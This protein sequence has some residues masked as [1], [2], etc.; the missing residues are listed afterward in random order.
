MRLCRVRW[1]HKQ[2]EQGVAKPEQGPSLQIYNQQSLQKTHTKPPKSH[3][4]PPNSIKHLQRLCQKEKTNTQPK[5]THTQPPL[6]PKQTKKA[7]QTKPKTN[8]TNH[9]VMELESNWNFWPDCS[10]D[11]GV[12]SKG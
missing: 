1:R 2:Q 3:T 6:F 11:M 9:E 4:H 7:P 10:S 12:T 5:Y 8:L